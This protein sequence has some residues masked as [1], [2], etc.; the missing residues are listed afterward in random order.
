MAFICTNFYICHRGP[1][2][3]FFFFFFN[4]LIFLDIV[5]PPPLDF[6]QKEYLINW[7]HETIINSLNSYLL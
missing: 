6:V 7:N 2:F 5:P 4:V 1:F 3:F